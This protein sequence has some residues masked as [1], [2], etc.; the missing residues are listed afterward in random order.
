MEYHS[1]SLIELKQLARDHNPPIKQYYIKSRI[2]LIRLLSLKELPHSFIIEKKTIAELRKEAISRG[3]KN[4]WKLKKSELLEL[5]YPSSQQN[6]QNN[7]QTKKH[8]NPEKG[9]GK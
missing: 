7:N 9:E 2:E 4:I 1:L 3:H 5:I 8:N 6:D